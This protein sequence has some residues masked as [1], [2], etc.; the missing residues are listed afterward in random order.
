VVVESCLRVAPSAILDARQRGQ[1]DGR[2][3]ALVQRR[4]RLLDGDRDRRLVVRREL[5]G[6]DRADPPAAD[7]DV[8]VLHELARVLEQQ[9]VL[10]AARPAEDQQVRREHHDEQECAEAGR[11]CDRHPRLSPTR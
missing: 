9:R 7:L 6:L 8:V 1:A 5:D 10:V 4:I 11:A 3:G 2:L